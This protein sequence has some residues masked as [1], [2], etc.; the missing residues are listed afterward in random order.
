M[1]RD[2]IAIIAAFVAT[3]AFIAAVA[4]H[5]VTFSIQNVA[6]FNVRIS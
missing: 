6:A 4:L 3:A 1:N 2:R 5:W